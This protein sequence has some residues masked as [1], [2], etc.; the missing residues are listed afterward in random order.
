MREDHW[1]VYLV[2]AVIVYFVL[3]DNL[4]LS[5]QKR[6]AKGPIIS[7]ILIVLGFLSAAKSFHWGAVMILPVVVIIT[8]V[9]WLPSVL[10]RLFPNDVLKERELRAEDPDW[11]R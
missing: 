2:S 10:D 3:R 8:S 4:K 1:L 6:G 5:Y 11:D 7:M 9:W